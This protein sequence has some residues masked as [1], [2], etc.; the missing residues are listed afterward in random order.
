MLAPLFYGLRAIFQSAPLLWSAPLAQNE[1]RLALLRKLWDCDDLRDQDGIDHLCLLFKE[2]NSLPQTAP[3]SAPLA[4]YAVT[5]SG[6][7]NG[8]MWSGPVRG[9]HLKRI[10]ALKQRGLIVMAFCI[11]DENDLKTRT[12]DAQAQWGRPVALLD[13]LGHGEMPFNPIH[14]PALAAGSHVILEACKAGIEYGLA[15]PL[16]QQ[17][18][19]ATVWAHQDPL[20]HS[21]PIFEIRDGRVDVRGVLCR[22]GALSW[23]WGAQ[24]RPYKASQRT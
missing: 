19:T 6:Y 22:T 12:E 17:N 20:G 9:W 10:K 2:E 8:A 13:A 23:L 16:A 7:D 4:V 15:Q 21:Q 14:L 11:E 5:V 24:M 1:T 18:P 3:P